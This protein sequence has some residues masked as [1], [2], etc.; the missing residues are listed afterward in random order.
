MPREHITNNTVDPTVN[1]RPISYS[2][3]SL[4]LLRIYVVSF[5]YRNNYC[6]IAPLHVYYI[7]RFLEVGKLHPKENPSKPH[8]R[9][10]N[11]NQANTRRKKQRRGV[12]GRPAPSASESY[13][14]NA[15]VTVVPVRN[16]FPNNYR[17]FIIG[18]EP[19]RP[20]QR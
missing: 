6:I 1:L 3:L 16:R 20:L 10:G 5:V 2:V 8:H 9:K 14:A 17:L 12:V 13:K 11:K 18:P 15:Y 4:L 7:R 19:V